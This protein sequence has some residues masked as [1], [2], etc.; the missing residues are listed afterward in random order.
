MVMCSDCF[1]Q[2]PDFY[3]KDMVFTPQITDLTLTNEQHHQITDQ[4]EKTQKINF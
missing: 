2:E 4:S 1:H 3:L